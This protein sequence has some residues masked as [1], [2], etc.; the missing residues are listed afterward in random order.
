MDGRWRG[1]ELPC[2]LSAKVGGEV[3]GGFLSGPFAVGEMAGAA[4]PAWGQLHRGTQLTGR[5]AV[6]RALNDV[7]C[8]SFILS[9]RRRCFFSSGE[10]L[11][12]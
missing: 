5:R 4:S 3:P 2:I 10:V 7:T 6:E 12:R 8:D 9:L 11:S 1:Q